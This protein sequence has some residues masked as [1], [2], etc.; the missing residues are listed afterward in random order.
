MLNDDENT[1]LKE[2]KSE[3]ITE[4]LREWRH[5]PSDTPLFLRDGPEGDKGNAQDEKDKTE[6]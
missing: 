2:P 4:P 5:S 1:N 6:E 3:K